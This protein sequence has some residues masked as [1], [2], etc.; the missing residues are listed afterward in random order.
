MGDVAISGT[1]NRTNGNEGAKT[2]IA[3]A[4]RTSLAMTKP[5]GNPKERLPR[6]LAQA[7]NDERGRVIARREGYSMTKPWDYMKENGR[8]S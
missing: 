7:R 2:E 1:E 4:H 6:L 8:D 3:S 5:L